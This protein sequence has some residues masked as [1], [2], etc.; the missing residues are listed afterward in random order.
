MSESSQT[1]KKTLWEKEK[2]LVPSYFSFSHSF[3][4]N[5][6]PANQGLFGKGLI[7]ERPKAWLKKY[8]VISDA[9]F[10]FKSNFSTTDAIFILNTFI[11]KQFQEK[12]PLFCCLTDLQKCFDFIYR[13]GLW[14][15]LIRQG[16]NGKLFS[17]IRTLY[18][19]VK[20]CVKHMNSVSDLYN[21]NVGLL[22]G[23]T[24]SPILFSLFVNNIELFLQLNTSHALHSTNLRYSYYCLRMILF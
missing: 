14:C 3:F 2:L 7:N 11:Q 22:Q 23:K 15:K 19:E 17:V 24:I 4:Q 21:C 16:I 5:A 10:G 20:L 18:D 1:R 13:N 8:D 6:C 9:Q 12:K